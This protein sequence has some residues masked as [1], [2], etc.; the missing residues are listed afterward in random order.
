MRP[1]SRIGISVP[2]SLF[3]V[4]IEIR[5]V[6]GRRARRTSSGSISPSPS[7]GRYVTG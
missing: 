1:I 5:I 4:W 3:A 6:S 7:T 2:L